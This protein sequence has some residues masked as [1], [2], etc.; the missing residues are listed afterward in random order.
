MTFSS[1][2][3]AMDAPKCVDQTPILH[4]CAD[5]RQARLGA[6][7]FCI[8]G[9]KADGHS[10]AQE[11]YQ[12]GVR[13]FVCERPLALP[14]DAKQVLVPNCRR[15]LAL[16]CAAFF[17][18]PYPFT[19][20]GITGTK[21]KTTVA[22]YLYQILQKN[23]IKVGMIGTTGIYGEG[24]FLSNPNTTPE[25]LLLH[26]TLSSF[27]ALGVQ[28]VILEV[29]SQAYLQHRLDGLHFD[30][31]IFTNLSHDHIGVEEHPDFDDYKQYKLQLFSHCSC[32]ILNYDDPH[33]ADFAAASPTRQFCYSL[34]QH[35]DCYLERV[36]GEGDTSF[37][38]VQFWCRAF[39]ESFAVTLS[40]PGKHNI[41]NALSAICVAR[42]ISV[43][44][45]AIQNALYTKVPGRFEQIPL[46][47]GAVAVIDYAHNEASLSAALRTLRPFV[48]GRLFCL[49]G[50]VGG[51]T[52][53]RRAQMGRVASSLCDFCIV[54]A[55]N[56]DYESPTQICAQIADAFSP[57]FPHK[58]ICDRTDAIRF[59]LE[60]LRPGDLLLLCGKG[61]E[62]YQKILG[63]S[64]PFCE[65]DILFLWESENKLQKNGKRGCKKDKK[66]VQ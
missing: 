20:I 8:V 17:G 29:S 51:R 42:L 66:K 43:P 54:T 16:A 65:K 46:S 38:G 57:S 23:G 44:I 1:L 7:F 24:T 63:Q 36:I 59:A 40:L 27:A 37:F 2:C 22:T 49:F 15:A 53:E 58:I 3:A 52:Q 47:C 21:G 9:A 41:A 5:S 18:A 55:D 56:P 45:E 4:L 50:S 25:P 64:I 33:Y 26:R 61:H 11:V 30:Y 39:E 14:Q 6:C 60:Q 35:V 12:K 62:G 19:L 28:Y 32:A 48:K 34:K 10:F 31:A 13:H